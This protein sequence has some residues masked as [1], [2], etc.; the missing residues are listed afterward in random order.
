MNAMKTRIFLADDHA[1]I[2]GKVADFLKD[3]Y[4]IV[5]IASDGQTALNE[6]IRQ[7]PDILL[8][9]ISMPIM[10]GIDAVANLMRLHTKT[11]IVFLTV[12]DD[13]DFVEAALA[14]GAAGYVIKSRMATDLIPAIREA[15]AGHR[16]ISPSIRSKASG[17]P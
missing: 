1:E 6:V 11:K 5:G 10:S 12:H 7:C 2:L 17:A 15:L 8:M 16:F 3:S 13:E 4:E 14:T 9:D